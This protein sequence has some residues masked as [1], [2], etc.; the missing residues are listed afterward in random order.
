MAG[1]ALPL[2]A[3][4]ELDR[5]V[6]EVVLAAGAVTT[7]SDVVVAEPAA[8]VGRPRPVAAPDRTSEHNAE[9][10]AEIRARLLWPP[11]HD[12]DQLNHALT[13]VPGRDRSSNL[14]GRC[15]PSRM[16]VATL[17]ARPGVVSG[18]LVYVP[19]ARHTRA[20]ESM[21][22]TLHFSPADEPSSCGSEPAWQPSGVACL[23]RC[24]A[25]WVENWGHRSILASSPTAGPL[26]PA[27]GT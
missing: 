14:Q 3:R 23:P 12:L 27:A 15:E 4:S 16:R 18:N 19:E 5:A 8:G 21:A 26:C 1:S 24:L 10:L 11:R 2:A 9:R 20:V 17:G 6:D 22:C 7:A 13:V 25:G